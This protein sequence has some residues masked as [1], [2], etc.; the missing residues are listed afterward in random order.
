MQKLL[1]V[2]ILAINMVVAKKA[3]TTPK[4]SVFTKIPPANWSQKRWVDYNDRLYNAFGRDLEAAKATHKPEAEH[5]AT[6]HLVA[7]DK[8]SDQ[9]KTVAFNKSVREFRLKT[10]DGKGQIRVIQVQG[11]HTLNR[12][13]NKAYVSMHGGANLGLSAIIDAEALGNVT[14]G[15]NCV[16]FFVD[17]RYAPH[18]KSPG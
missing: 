10:L 6:G 13:D 17:Y 14:F 16:M 7:L 12:T 8:S 18:T 9:Y 1:L 4:N 11:L 2:L 15:T 5:N 3:I